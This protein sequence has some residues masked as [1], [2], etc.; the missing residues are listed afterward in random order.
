MIKN[1]IKGEYLST[2][3][4][5]RRL[6]IWGSGHF[7]ASIRYAMDRIGVEVAGF[8]DSNMS[9]SE[10]VGFPVKNPN[11]ILAEGKNNVFIIISAFLF[12]D[13]IAKCCNEYGFSRSKDYLTHADIKP[14]HFEIDVAGCCNLRCITCPRGN[15]PVSDSVRGMMS[16]GNYKKALDKLI[17]EIPM[18]SDVQLYSWGE[19]LLNPQLPEIIAYTLSQ[20]L[21]TA[22]SSNLSLLCDL[23]SVVKSMPTWFRVS[24]SGSDEK[25]YSV[26]HRSGNLGLVVKNLRLL[27]QLRAEFAPE[28]FVEVN[29]HLYKHNLDGITKMAQL[30]KDLGFVF[31][32][33]YAFIDPLDSI[34]EYAKGNS[35]S[36]VMEA[37]RQ[38]LLLD[39]DD[40]IRL[41]KHNNLH[42]CVS[43][44]SFVIHCDL[45]F[46]RCTH[47]YSN[48]S[49]VIA[50]N[51]LETPLDEI[52]RRAE[53]CEICR[54]CR[55]LGVHRFHFGYINKGTELG[56]R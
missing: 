48:S 21:A 19:P 18:L 53:N 23:E 40:A 2:L 9:G 26:I 14:Y 29:Y 17:L 22:V 15:S 43:E 54:T 31:R 13:E 49:N 50:D 44:N 34:I 20:G 42:D 37:G 27:S 45:S 6:Y 32:T 46:R 4:G 25:T 5:N 30:C 52:L 1:I 10:F 28:M 38:H 41:S 47:L 16:F 56:L 8:I 33:N 39:I 24:L 7:G 11:D 3:V 35:L 12:V 51:F 55:F 36:K